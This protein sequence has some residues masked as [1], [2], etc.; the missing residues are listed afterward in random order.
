MDFRW[1]RKLS[2]GPKTHQIA[3]FISKFS[4]GGDAPWPPRLF[5]IHILYRLA[6]RLKTNVCRS[7]VACVHN[8]GNLN[9]Y[10][11]LRFWAFS[12][13]SNEQKTGQQST[14]HCLYSLVFV[15][16][17][18]RCRSQSEHCDF[19]ILHIKWWNIIYNIYYISSFHM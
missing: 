3:P 5:W 13:A 19:F 8:I 9:L 16:A 18:I 10:W 4:R 7:S 14:F 2:G 17:D 6:T 12:H 1:S 15:Y 11:F